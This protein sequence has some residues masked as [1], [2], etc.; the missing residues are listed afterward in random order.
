[1]HVAF[2][3]H[4]HIVNKL[5]FTGLL[6]DTF[7]VF[8]G[9]VCVCAIQFYSID[10]GSQTRSKICSTWWTTKLIMNECEL[11]N[12]GYKTIIPSDS[13]NTI[14]V[15][16]KDNVLNLATSFSFIFSPTRCQICYHFYTNVTKLYTTET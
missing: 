9:Y 3:L 5:F 4:L 14:N 7:Y 11:S 6:F 10:I 2:F 12:E 16:C 13:S 15:Y 1:M 8:A